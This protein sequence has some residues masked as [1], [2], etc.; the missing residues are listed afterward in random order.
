MPLNTKNDRELWDLFREGKNDALGEL[1]NR[2]RLRIL[3][4][5]YHIIQKNYTCAN[6]EEIKDALQETSIKVLTGDRTT[7]VIDFP[8]WMVQYVINVWRNERRKTM[9]R[10]RIN[11]ESLA[12]LHEFYEIDLLIEKALDRSRYLEMLKKITSKSYQQIAYFSI[13]EGKTNQEIADFF[14]KK[15]AWVADK[16]YRALKQYHDILQEE[17]LIA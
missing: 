11:R 15:K 8:R 10:D 7:N 6:L 17:G 4:V 14:G 2:H 13:F 16:K 3:A 9:N 5:T 1:L 12:P